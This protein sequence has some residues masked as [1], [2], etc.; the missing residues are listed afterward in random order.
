ME[1]IMFH[2]HNICLWAVA[3]HEVFNRMKSVC[4]RKLSSTEKGV[5]YCI[6]SISSAVTNALNLSL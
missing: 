2:M 4:A 6:S 3:K 5:M 1:H